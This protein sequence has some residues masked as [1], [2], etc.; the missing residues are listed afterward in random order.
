MCA[1]CSL[2]AAALLPGNAGLYS[3]ASSTASNGGFEIINTAA[4]RW[5]RQSRESFFNGLYTGYRCDVGCVYPYWYQE[6]LNGAEWGF[7]PQSQAQLPFSQG[8]H[9]AATNCTCSC[10]ARTAPWSMLYG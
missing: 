5:T 10:N 1:L 6:N 3:L 8:E 4:S 7:D 2:A 9:T